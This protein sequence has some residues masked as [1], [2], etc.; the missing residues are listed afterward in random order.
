MGVGPVSGAEQS[1]AEALPFPGVIRI[2][3]AGVCNLRCVHCPTGTVPMRRGI[4]SD[5]TF[6]RLAAGL[7]PHL[8]EIRVAVL[9]HGGE[10]L[11]NDRLFEMVRYLKSVGIPFVKMVS[12]GM[13]MTE[14]LAKATIESGLDAIEFSLDGQ[15]VDENNFLRRNGDAGIVLL[16]IKALLDVQ[17]KSEAHALKVHI[18]STQFLQDVTQFDCPPEVPDW[19]LDEFSGDYQNVVFKT[20]WAMEWP[21]MV[22]DPE[23]FDVVSNPSGAFCNQC[24]HVE[25]E[26][27][28]RWNGDVVA[29]CYDLTS[30][31]VLGNIYEA[32]LGSIW[33]NSKYRTIRNAIRSREPIP[34]CASCNV[35]RPEVFL[36]LRPDVVAKFR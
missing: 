26:L 11:L 30:S 29:C 19:L 20:A 16:N 31:F 35:V 15:S 32:E 1:M 33:N 2:E 34:L 4:M 6:S 22:V 21:V 18:A 27:T 36:T 9:Y 14:S 8:D 25:N 13:L 10:P 5:E 17:K 28:V 3:P 12:N 7:E 24:G 23:I